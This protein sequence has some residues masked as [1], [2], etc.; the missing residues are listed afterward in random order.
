MNKKTQIGLIAGIILFM[1]L[2]VWM[3]SAPEE[4]PQAN[5]KTLRKPYVS[6]N[7]NTRYQLNDKHPLGLYLFT[8]LT[9]AH[10]DTS[11]RLKSIDDTYA[12]DSIVAL[13]KKKTYLFVG[14]NFGLDSHEMDSILADVKRGSVLFMSF[15][16]LTE[17]LYPRLFE[18]YSYRIDYGTEVNVFMN[19]H[20][21]NMINI[22]QNDTIACDWWAFGD[23]EFE[24]AH[25]EL[26]S[27]M[28]LPNF[29]KV[30][31]G[32]GYVFLHSSPNMFFNYQL[33]RKSGFQYTASVLNEL[34]HNQDIFLLELGRLK[35][36]YGSENTNVKEGNGGKKDDSYLKEILR[37]PMLRTAMLLSIL[38]MLLFVIFRSKRKRPVVPYL[39]K[40]KDMT[41]AFAE[42]I[43]S[44]YFAKRNAYGL[45]QVQKKNFYDAMHRHFFVD[46]Y[47]RDGDREMQVLSEKTNTPIEEIRYFVELFETKQASA[48]TDQLVAD[49]A[50]KKYNFYKKVGI[51]SDKISEKVE[52][53]EM[54]FRRAMLLPAIMLLGGLG[55]IITG[56]YFLTTSQ[57][58][59]IAQVPIGILLVILGSIRLSKPCLVISKDKMTYFSTF[60]MKREF[61]RDNLISTEMRKGGVIF[62]FSNN[63][64]LIINFWDL[65]RFDRKQFER[66]VSKLHTLEL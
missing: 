12:L 21:F 44:I 66:L 52:V 23:L 46:L 17:N 33:K 27:F 20:K 14:N 29:V 58:I 30:K 32:D 62:T 2:M 48:I 55:I 8:S 6:S 34:P 10:L 37:N 18:N 9:K 3:F 7:W 35:D 25:V 60:G 28:E 39:A 11:K 59:G 16:D 45:L 61:L 54:I 36:D 22:F 50:K 47:K 43:T 31:C 49:T 42:T 41:L 19:K 5:N 53:R 57:G 4:K 38:G 15:N 26:S 63:K 65:S 51:I 64:K 40:R 13:K 24:E 56:F 1:F